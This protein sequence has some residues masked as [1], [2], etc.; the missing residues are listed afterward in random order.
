[1]SDFETTLHKF[2]IALLSIDR[3]GAKRIFQSMA[4]IKEPVD[5]A[6]SLVVPVLESIGEKW[7][8]GTV[9]LSQVYMSGKICEEL[10]NTILPPENPMVKNHPKMAI[11][12]FEDFHILGKKIVHSIIRASGY[13]LPEW[14]QGMEIRE[15]VKKVE[16]EQIE[17]LLISTLMLSSALRIKTLIENLRNKN[18]KVKVI[19]GGAPFRFDEHLCEEIGADAFGKSASEAVSIIRQLTGGNQK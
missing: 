19:V 9:A 4:E 6:D 7:E 5:V 16:E 1:M 18:L 8:K 12:V 3:I 11:L 2:E 10:I 13:N 17:I 14:N 15:I